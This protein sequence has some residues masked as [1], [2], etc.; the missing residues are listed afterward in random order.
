MIKKLFTVLE[1]AGI[2]VYMP[3]KKTGKCASPYAVIKE[4]K[5]ELNATGKSVSIFFSVSVVV[6]LD[7]YGMLDEADRKVKSALKGSAFKFQ[8]NSDE[9]SDGEIGGYIRKLIYTAKKRAVCTT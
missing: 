6:P 5:T 8:G 7:S 2:E 1:G 3:A 4:E 9:E